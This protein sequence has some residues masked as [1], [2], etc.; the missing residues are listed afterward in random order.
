MACFTLISTGLRVLI[1]DFLMLA[2]TRDQDC[3]KEVNGGGGSRSSTAEKLDRAE[4]NR[5]LRMLE[6]RDKITQS[7]NRS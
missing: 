6:A 3:G 7:V 4:H 1:I 5:T 2:G